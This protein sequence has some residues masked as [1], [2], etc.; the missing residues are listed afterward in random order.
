MFSRA[1]AAC[2]GSVNGVSACLAMRRAGLWRACPSSFAMPFMLCG[3][4]SEVREGLE[5]FI[6]AGKIPDCATAKALGL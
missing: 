4:P 1:S 3:L 5:K 2:E 6:C